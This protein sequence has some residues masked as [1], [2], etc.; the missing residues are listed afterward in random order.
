MRSVY[1]F[2]S[3]MVL[4]LSISVGSIGILSSVARGDSAAA[5]CPSFVG[6]PSGLT[7]CLVAKCGILKLKHC[8]SFPIYDENGGFVDYYCDCVF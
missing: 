6:F 3:M 2:A 5:P 7:I 4:A 1:R 8:Q